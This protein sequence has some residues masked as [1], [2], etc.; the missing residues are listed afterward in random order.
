MTYVIVRVCLSRA[1]PGAALPEARRRQ[2]AA[3]GEGGGAEPQAAAQR[4]APHPGQT[5]RRLRAHLQQGRCPA[6]FAPV[7]VC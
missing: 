2:P 1:G 4:P 6:L 5:A 7:S 3:A